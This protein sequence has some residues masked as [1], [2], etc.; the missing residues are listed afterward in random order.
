MCIYMHVYICKY[1]F[2]LL[3]VEQ[4]REV[5]VATKIGDKIS[6]LNSEEEED[7]CIMSNMAPEIFIN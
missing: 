1:K 2:L 7:I 3:N 5:I 6:G 4:L